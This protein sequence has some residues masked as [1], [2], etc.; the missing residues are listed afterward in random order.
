MKKAAREERQV[1][2]K[3]RDFCNLWHWIGRKKRDEQDLG[4]RRGR[5]GRQK[6][7]TVV[8]M[9]A[10]IGVGFPLPYKLRRLMDPGD[11]VPPIPPEYSET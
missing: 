9:G 7:A 3:W 11:R 5:R 6:L 10:A 2:A 1:A 8:A 4:I